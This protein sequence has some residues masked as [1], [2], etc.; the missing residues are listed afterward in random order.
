[1]KCNNVFTLFFYCLSNKKLVVSYKFSEK[2]AGVELVQIMK[3]P[4][5]F[6]IIAY[7][8]MQYLNSTNTVDKQYFTFL[9]I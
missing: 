2:H 7:V 8:T 9:N 6:L 4:V 3:A 5:D 1:M